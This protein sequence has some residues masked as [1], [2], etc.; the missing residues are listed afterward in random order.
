MITSSDFVS[1]TEEPLKHNEDPPY[2]TER[3]RQL[4]NRHG[5]NLAI[6]R[7]GLVKGGKNV[8]TYD[9]CAHRLRQ[10]MTESSIAIKRLLGDFSIWSCHVT[11]CVFCLYFRNVIIFHR[12]HA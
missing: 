10:K 4:F 2:K 11:V 6:L 7:G 1:A 12:F 3:M 5:Y 9:F 8:K